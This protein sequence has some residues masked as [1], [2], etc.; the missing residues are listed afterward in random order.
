MEA[1]IRELFRQ[2]GNDDEKLS[3]GIEELALRLGP[4]VYQETLFQLTSKAYDPET[5]HR[6]WQGALRH[7]ARL[8]PESTP[9][10]GLRPAL[11][12]YFHSV[13][14]EMKDPRIVEAGHLEH[15]RLASITD[16]LT[17][18]YNQSYFKVQLEMRPLR[19]SERGFCPETDRRTLQTES[20]SGGHR[21]SLRGRGI[22]PAA[23][24]GKTP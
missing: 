15:I 9:A 6:H 10:T 18:L 3:D 14:Q 1:Q 13:A 5:A 4:A 16:G 11:L 12:D 23:V 21:L 2:W 22:R 17:G 7:R 19:T 8:F 24:P 20:A